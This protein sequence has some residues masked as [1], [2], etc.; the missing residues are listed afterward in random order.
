[1]LSVY[2]NCKIL[3]L[4]VKL[5]PHRFISLLRSIINGQINLLL[6]NGGQLILLIFKLTFKLV[7]ISSH[8]HLHSTLL[9]VFLLHQRVCSVFH[10]HKSG[11]TDINTFTEDTVRQSLAEYVNVKSQD[12]AGFHDITLVVLLKTIQLGNQ[13]IE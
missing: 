11:F 7:F 8:S 12:I 3:E 5:Y 9:K 1:M 6:V 13:L 10:V 2:D 4:S